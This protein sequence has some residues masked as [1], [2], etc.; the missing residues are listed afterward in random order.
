MICYD[1][2]S[3]SKYFLS[4]YIRIKKEA[5]SVIISQE[6]FG[7]FMKINGNV[8]LLNDLLISL[9]DGLDK[10]SLLSSLEKAGAVNGVE[11][12]D[13]IKEMTV[14]GIIE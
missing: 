10:S 13:M 14:K 4:P 8:L 7:T 11:A 12:E 5:D 1:S 3:V 9:E 2:D 6:L